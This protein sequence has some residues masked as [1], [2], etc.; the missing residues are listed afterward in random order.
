M[1]NLK[2]MGR[3]CSIRDRPFAMS[4][5]I[6]TGLFLLYFYLSKISNYKV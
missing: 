5:I 2:Q 3:R 6:S 4:T 1:N